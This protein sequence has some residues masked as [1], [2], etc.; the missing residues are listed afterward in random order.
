MRPRVPPPTR[1]C[2]SASSTTASTPTPSAA[3]SAGTARSAERLAAAGHDV[4]Y[5]TLRQWPKGE[6]PDVPG[7]RVVE[8]GP[9]F[10]LYAVD[11]R[12]RIWPAIR[13]GF[14]VFRHLLRHGRR[15]DVVHTAADAVLRARAR[16]GSLGAGVATGRGRLDR[17]LDA[18][19]LA[20]V[21]RRCRRQD[22][23]GGSSGWR[24]A[25]ATRRSASRGST[26]GGCGTRA[27]GADRR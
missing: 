17:G 10:E 12:R 2:A 26:R 1:S 15:Y 9:R 18:R 19:L 3:A 7:V 14:G 20:R 5:L 27:S 22:R 6:H 13:F 23:L 4:T 16:P 8:V 24:R 21:P 11:G 25:S